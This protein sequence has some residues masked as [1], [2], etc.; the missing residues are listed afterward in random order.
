MENFKGFKIVHGS[1]SNPW[2]ILKA[3]TSLEVNWSKNVH[4]SVSK[5]WKILNNITQAL[6]IF[7]NCMWLS[8]K[9]SEVFKRYQKPCSF[10]SQCWYPANQ[11]G[12][13]LAYWRCSTVVR[14][15][16]TGGYTAEWKQFELLTD[17]SSAK[18]STLSQND[19]CNCNEVKFCWPE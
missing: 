19:C 18:T 3:M 15:L 4:G 14:G 8:F 2:K 16:R 9:G 10:C 1:V 13:T 7:Y 5:V 12:L 17:V 6:W 11:F